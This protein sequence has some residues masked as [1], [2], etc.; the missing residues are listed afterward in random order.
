MMLIPY[1]YTVGWV[2]PPASL[3]T[4]MT[5][6]LVKTLYSLDVAPGGGDVPTLLGIILLVRCTRESL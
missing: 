2:I 6:L 1:L 5:G 4:R 3:I